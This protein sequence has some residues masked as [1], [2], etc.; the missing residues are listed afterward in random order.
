[1][2]G[3]ILYK[4]YE[5]MYSYMIL[6]TSDIYAVSLLLSAHAGIIIFSLCHAHSVDIANKWA[7]NA[8]DANFHMRSSRPRTKKQGRETKETETETDTDKWIIHN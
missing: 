2:I 7:E 1:M 4:L 6:N 5:L 8:S 3:Q